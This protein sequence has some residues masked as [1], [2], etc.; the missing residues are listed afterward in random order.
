MVAAPWAAEALAVWG[1]WRYRRWRRGG[2]RGREGWR[3]GELGFH[4]PGSDLGLAIFHLVFLHF[5]L[6]FAIF[7]QTGIVFLRK[8]QYSIHLI[9]NQKTYSQLINVN[10]F[11]VQ[12]TE[13]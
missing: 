9:L 10:I 11:Y 8:A 12:Q 7:F 3:G 13:K 1:R 5:L 6:F 4:G 2:Q